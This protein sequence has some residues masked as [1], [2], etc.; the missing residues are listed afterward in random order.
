[1]NLNQS[2]IIKAVTELLR[3]APALD[4]VKTIDRS[5][6]INDNPELAP[7]VGVFRVRTKYS[8]L[9][10]GQHSR[11]WLAEVSID[12]VIQEVSYD[13]GEAAEVKLEDLVTDIMRVLMDNLTLKDKVDQITGFEQEYIF[14][15]SQDEDSDKFFFQ[16]TVLTIEAEV[17]TG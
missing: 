15:P 16:T 12:I 10:L 6:F 7:W 14:K 11:S 4:V 2:D 17:R 3:D 9:Q 1:M 13:S 5:E 8:P